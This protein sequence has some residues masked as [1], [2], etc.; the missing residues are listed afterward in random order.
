MSIN[1]LLSNP[2]ILDELQTIVNN[3]IPPS[4]EGI[5]TLV[6]TDNNFDLSVLG[7]VGTVNLSNELTLNQ[8]TSAVIGN[9]EAA[10]LDITNN[11]LD[12][13]LQV[14]GGVNPNII[15]NEDSASLKISS[16]NSVILDSSGNLNFN[17]VLL[18]TNNMLNPFLLDG[19]NGQLLKTDGNNNLSW[20]N[21]SSFSLPMGLKN[22]FQTSIQ[23]PVAENTVLE[24][25]NSDISGFTV[26]KK[27][28]ITVNFTF[29]TDDLV[30]AI[31]LVKV[32]NVLAKS[33][34]TS[35][36]NVFVHTY[37]GFTVNY[38]NTSTTQNLSIIIETNGSLGT[39]FYTDGADYISV[40]IN[41]IQ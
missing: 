2:I 28:L 32:D 14:T 34:N 17:N 30:N 41:E 1:S 26:G 18:K 36:N 13:K 37:R 8:I 3:Y 39:T 5:T 31:V 21:S 24:L 10:K 12:L 33:I 27:I 15:L 16:I 11:E 22:I 4:Q 6:N 23:Q 38:L 19:T 40:V 29:Y 7:N 9:N 35:I 25:Y 20:V